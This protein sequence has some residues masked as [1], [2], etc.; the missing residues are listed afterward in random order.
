MYENVKIVSKHGMS[1][2]EPVW[3]EWTGKAIGWKTIIPDDVYKPGM[4]PAFFSFEVI[5]EKGNILMDLSSG[6]TF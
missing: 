3:C 5:D 4:T 6:W 2:V 1:E